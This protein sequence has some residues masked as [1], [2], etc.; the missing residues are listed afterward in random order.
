MPQELVDSERMLAGLA[1][2][3][4][5]VTTDADGADV[6]VVNTC[7]FL[8]LARAESD[9]HLDALETLKRRGR[10][11]R[12]VVAGCM[13]QRYGREILRRHPTVDAIVGISSRDTLADICRK[14]VEGPRARGR[15]RSKPPSQRAAGAETRRAPGYET[16]S[17]S[18]LV[19]GGS[20]H[21]PRKARSAPAALVSVGP[22]AA[23]P[24]DDRERLRLTPRHY[25]YLRISE[26]C[27]N[28][29]AYCAIPEIRGPLRSKPPQQV[30]AEAEELAAD[31]A[32]E[33]ILIAQDTTAYGHDL[34][35]QQGHSAAGLA[36]PAGKIADCE[37]RIA[38]LKKRSGTNP[39]DIS[40]PAVQ[41][42]IRKEFTRLGGQS[43]IGGSA[44]M[45]HLLHLLLELVRVP[46]LRLMYTHPAS[47]T[48]DVIGQLGVR[49][50]VPYVDLPLQHIS[51]AILESMGR[52]TGRAEIESL[53]ARLRA[54]APGIA[55]RTS[56]IVGYPGETDAHF[57][58]L[59]GFVEKVRFDHVGVFVYSAEAGTRAAG[60]PDQVPAA[61]AR[62]RWERLMQA[63]ERLAFAAAEARRG[64]V[65]EVLVDGAEESGRLVAR[66]AGQAPEVDG[67]VLLA[68]GTAAT[69]QFAK[70]RITGAEGYDLLGEVEDSSKFQVPSSK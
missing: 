51:D 42:A 11:G 37:L 43:S 66:H 38:D 58:E 54:A 69:G 14:V 15:G 10:L 22:H 67:V 27:D 36:P 33:L 19:R 40:L 9:Q 6:A 53:L 1:L 16:V 41:S 39:A 64:Q 8:D 21:P 52:R 18:R 60:L 13:A 24:P 7:A 5:A 3:G 56:F 46:W 59:L 48:E 44:S 25:A 45:A 65:L 32:K 68:P 30:L 62:E 17:E 29:C 23:A 26:G 55:I 20:P 50:L 49:P 4:F 63:A 12:I 28:R 31:G 2:G 61:V 35:P 57:E 47:F 70:V 34:A